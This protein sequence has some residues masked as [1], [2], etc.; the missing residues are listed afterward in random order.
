VVEAAVVIASKSPFNLRISDDRFVSGLTDLVK[1]IREVNR[2][3]RIGLQIMQHSSLP[4]Q[5]GGRGLRISRRR[6]LRIS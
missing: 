4:R 5:V 2:E 6:N 3:V 1:A